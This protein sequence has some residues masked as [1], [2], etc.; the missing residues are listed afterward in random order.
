MESAALALMGRK[1]QAALLLYG[2]NAASA[3][4]DEAGGSG[5]FTAE[6]AARILDGEELNSGGITRLLKKT[7]S[8]EDKEPIWQALDEEEEA[9][10]DVERFDRQIKCLR[11]SR[12]EKPSISV[13]ANK[14]KQRVDWSSPPQKI[15]GS[16][17]V[18]ERSPLV[19]TCVAA[20]CC[21]P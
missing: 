4:T 5:D 7:I 17:I 3:I 2:D 21:E 6:L 13:V 16:A 15:K 12:R 14:L 18:D 1:M 19:L 20:T 8:D 10:D 11:S 9:F